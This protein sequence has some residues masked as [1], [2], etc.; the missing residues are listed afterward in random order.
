VSA[1]LLL[2]LHSLHCGVVWD[3]QGH[4]IRDGRVVF[5]GDRIVA[6]GPAITV[7]AAPEERDLRPLFCMPG[8]VDAHTHVTSYVEKRG[9]SEEHRH[10]QA[11]KNA[12][13]TVEAGVTTGRDLGDSLGDGRWIRDLIK[14]GKTPGPRL[15]VACEQIGIDPAQRMLPPEGLR[16]VVREHVRDGCDV[17]KLFAT[18]GIGG[19]ERFLSREQLAAAVDEAHKQGRK[20]AVHVIG[21]DAIADT[22]AAG[23]DSVDHGTGATV[24]IAREMKRKGIVLVP[25]LY[26]LRYYVEDA[27]NIGYTAEHV[28]A[29]NHSIEAF[30]KP[31]ERRLPEIIKTG[32]TIAAGS[33]SF[34]KLHGRNAT[35]MVWLVRAGLPAERALLAMTRVSAELMGWGDRVGSLRK[36]Y[37]ADVVALDGDPRKDITFVE[38]RHVRFVLSGGQVVKKP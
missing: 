27:Q 12:R 34:M 17:I 11:Q 5:E 21:K 4:A 36:G 26:I 28:A 14:A 23:A 22:V 13:L 3:G 30:V 10:D 31:F 25:T 8:F 32:V 33:D 19:D 24:A 2:T 20:V 16:E 1:L 15:Q 38:V 6:V 35:E 29:L 7:K 37:Y 9:D 18:T